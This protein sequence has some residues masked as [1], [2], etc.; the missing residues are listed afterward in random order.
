MATTQA[1]RTAAHR[2][3]RALLV[4]FLHPIGPAAAQS[5]A[6]SPPPAPYSLPW[7][8]RPAMP[9]SVVRLDE[10]LAFFEDPASGASG[11]TYVTSL[12]ATWR[13]SPSWVPIFRQTFIHDAP[14][15]GG[16][17]SADAF[18]NPLLGIN[19][20]HSLRGGWRWTGFF[21]ST[22]PVGSGGGDDPDPGKAA[23]QGAAIPARSAMDNALFA[24]NYWTVIGGLG[25]A[26]ITPG[27]TLQAEVTVLQLFRVRGPQSQDD[28]RTNLT[29][30]LHAGHF[31]SPRISL[32]AEVRLQNWLTDAAPVRNDPSARQ[33]LTVGLGP[34]FHFKLGGGRV[35]RPGLSYT[36]AFDDPMKR[37]GYDVVQVD[38]PFAF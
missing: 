15:G 18:S 34:R 4:A 33:Q 26:R 21:A 32:G 8:L 1:H 22:I 24:V 31:F 30:G 6:S 7:L 38:V 28:S 20:F 27:L 11:G 23:A 16:T 25:L 35:L 5:P 10:T 17:P 3:F 9:G 12:I 2:I 36:R 14:P 37:S 13:A 29:A 19:Y